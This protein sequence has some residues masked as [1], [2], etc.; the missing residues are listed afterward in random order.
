ML[1]LAIARLAR[2]EPD[3]PVLE[4]MVSMGA[5]IQNLLLTAHA[6]DTGTGLTSGQAMRSPRLAA[7]CALGADES[8]VFCINIGSV[9]RHKPPARV[10]PAPALF[11]SDLP[12][13]AVAG[14]RSRRSMQ[15]GRRALRPNRPTTRRISVP[16]SR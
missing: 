12:S 13:A 11:F 10:R 1:L 6:M 7:L 8:P 16:S 9:T 4:R 3:T 14:E 5:A 2:S 15:R